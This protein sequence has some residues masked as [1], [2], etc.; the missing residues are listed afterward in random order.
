MAVPSAQH[1][2]R[3]ERARAH[4]CPKPTELTLANISRAAE[5]ANHAATRYHAPAWSP[6]A[7]NQ[8]NAPH[9]HPLSRA[10]N[11]HGS[12]PPLAVAVSRDD[13]PRESPNLLKQK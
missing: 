1:V 11:W 6:V 12:C 2:D 13:R 9:A 8:C 3:I 7:A 10:L 5:R 4:R